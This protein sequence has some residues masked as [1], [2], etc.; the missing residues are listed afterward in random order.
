M[1]ILKKTA[2]S[3][4]FCLFA[5]TLLHAQKKRE[6]QFG[7]AVLYSKSL[8][9]KPVAKGGKLNCDAMTAAHR[10]FPFGTKIRVTNLKNDKSVIVRIND[11]G[12]YSKKDIIDMTPSAAKAIGLTMKNGRVRVRIDVLSYG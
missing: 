6:P 12:P 1:I 4:A 10:K 8:C 2:I 5:T 11:R 7:N 3:L 9:G